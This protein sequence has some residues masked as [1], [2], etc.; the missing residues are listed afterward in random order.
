MV[1]IWSAVTAE[2]VCE[3]LV[4][5]HPVVCL[6]FS[7]DSTTVLAGSSDGG[8]RMWDA[9]KGQRRGESLRLRGAIRVVA[10]SPDGQIAAAA[11]A[12]GYEDREPSGEVQLCQ[13]ETGQNLGGALVHPRPVSGLAFSPNGRILLTAC[14]DG[15]A[16]VFLTATAAPVGKPF[17]VR[18]AA[19]TTVAIAPDGSTAPH[20]HVRW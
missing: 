13:V 17:L 19:Q 7:P 8:V 11:G 14:D 9:K 4:A 10:F 20:S 2:P 5:T 6:A 1:R 18:G 3:P 15:R 16:R 12:V